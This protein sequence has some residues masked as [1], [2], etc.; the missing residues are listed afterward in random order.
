MRVAAVRLK[1]TITE[2]H[3]EVR[4]RS[5]NR[6]WSG[7]PGVETSPSVYVL[8]WSLDFIYF[9]RFKSF[10]VENRQTVR[11]FLNDS[12]RNKSKLLQ[13]YQH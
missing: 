5:L 7:I 9:N 8:Q 2:L 4:P 12:Q 10:Q 3:F 6:K 13:F 11:F 1:T